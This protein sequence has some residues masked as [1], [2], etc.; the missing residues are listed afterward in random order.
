MP[1]EE[2][3][4]KRSAVKN[5]YARP[6]SVSRVLPELVEGPVEGLVKGHRQGFVEEPQSIKL[7][8]KVQFINSAS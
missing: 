7:N 1:S 4:N 5:L 3:E 2:E 8:V 6:P